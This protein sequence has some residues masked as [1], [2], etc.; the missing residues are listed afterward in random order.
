MAVPVRKPV[1]SCRRLHVSAKLLK[2]FA[3]HPVFILGYGLIA[4]MMQGGPAEK[5]CKTRAG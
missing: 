2:C 4:T 1:L 5:S 3:K